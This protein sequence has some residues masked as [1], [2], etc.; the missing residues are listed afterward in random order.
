MKG[1]LR[2]SL[3][4]CSALLCMKS[5]PIQFSSNIDAHKILN[6]GKYNYITFMTIRYAGQLS[7]V[8]LTKVANKCN[9][10]TPSSFPHTKWGL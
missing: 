8:I 4:R 3:L 6:S 2:K 9:Q 10:F 7:M 1:L 5:P